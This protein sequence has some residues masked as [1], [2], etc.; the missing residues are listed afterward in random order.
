MA[1]RKTPPQTYA[2]VS[3]LMRKQR[4][5]L[6]V[7]FIVSP[8]DEQQLNVCAWYYF[9][10]FSLINRNSFIVSPPPL[11]IELFFRNYCWHVSIHIAI[12]TYTNVLATPAILS[13]IRNC[14]TSRGILE[15][16]AAMYE[17]FPL[18]LCVP[19]QSIKFDNNGCNRKQALGVAVCSCYGCVEWSVELGAEKSTHIRLI[20]ED[21]MMNNCFLWSIWPILQG[22]CECR[23]LDLSSNPARFSFRRFIKR[24][25]GW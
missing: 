2:S 24:I 8:Y 18:K 4:N 16:T 13:L 9:V 15:T 1:K 10:L 21:M 23:T 6:G 14:M 7:L 5:E 25:S 3:H 12:R 19:W 11:I 17:L 22:S 20:M